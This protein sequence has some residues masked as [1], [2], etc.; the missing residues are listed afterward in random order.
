MAEITINVPQIETEIE[1]GNKNTDKI[2]GN[3]KSF[4]GMIQGRINHFL[5]YP[6]IKFTGREVEQLLTALMRSYQTFHP[7]TKVAV[8]LNPSKGKSGFQVNVFPE[9]FQIIEWRKIESS[10]E[11]IKHRKAKQLT[12]TVYKKAFNEVLRALASIEIGKRYKTSEFAEIWARTNHIWE[13]KDGRKL[14]D[15]DGFNFANLSGNRKTYFPFY[16][17]IKILEHYKIIKYEDSG[18][19][20]KLKEW[21]DVK[22]I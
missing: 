16:Y 17:S 5:K 20:T 19:I 9:Y 8:E 11:W 2:I 7:E 13:N 10:E 12:Y 22:L 3:A 21:E 18:H 6:D 4:K 15:N 1:L 14:I